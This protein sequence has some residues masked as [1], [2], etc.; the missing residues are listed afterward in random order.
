MLIVELDV[1]G[2]VGLEPPHEEIETTATA[3]AN[4]FAK[5]IV[6]ILRS[7][8]LCM[9]P[10]VQ[11]KYHRLIPSKTQIAAWRITR[12]VKRLRGALTIPRRTIRWMGLFKKMDSSHRPAWFR[13]A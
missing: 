8:P 9:A 10:R 1:E 4:E 2:V 7:V 12:D 3:H 11:G 6:E 5:R 13:A